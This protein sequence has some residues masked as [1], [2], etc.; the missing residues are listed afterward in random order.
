M[1]TKMDPVPAFK[2]RQELGGYGWHFELFPT[3]LNFLLVILVIVLVGNLCHCVVVV[4][5]F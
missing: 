5:V 2:R 4:V 1:M 3:L